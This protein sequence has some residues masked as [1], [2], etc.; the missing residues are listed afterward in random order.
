MTGEIVG[1][2]SEEIMRQY[3]HVSSAAAREAMDRL[4]RHFSNALDAT[5]AINSQP[6]A[7]LSTVSG[8]AQP[9]VLGH[10]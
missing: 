5:P 2:A 6:K 1:H 8:A 9:S 7:S 10:N 3:Q 4:S